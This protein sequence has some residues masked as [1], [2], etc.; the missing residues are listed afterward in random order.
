LARSGTTTNPRAEVTTPRTHD[1]ADTDARE[2][3]GGRPCRSGHGVPYAAL[4]V[5]QAGGVTVTL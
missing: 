3:T 2:F 4:M 1:V 5:L